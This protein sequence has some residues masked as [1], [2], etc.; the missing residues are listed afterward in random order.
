MRSQCEH[1]LDM[2]ELQGISGFTNY[3]KAFNYVDLEKLWVALEELG[4]SQHLIIL[5][6]N[7]CC[8]QEATVRIE[9]RETEWFAVGKG[10]RRRC[11]LSLSLLHLYTYCTYKKLG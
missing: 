2:G 3:S 9:C 1:W 8:R 4:A 10:A 11:I 7:L 5:K 6:R